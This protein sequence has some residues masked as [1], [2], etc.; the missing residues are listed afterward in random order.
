RET[1]W[2][3]IL[4]E[5]PDGKVLSLRWTA[6]L[7]GSVN[8]GLMDFARAADLDAAL[9]LADRTA[10]PTQ[11]L[12]IGDSGGNIPWRLLGPLPERGEGCPTRDLV[13]NAPASAAPDRDPEAA[14]Q[15]HLGPCPPWRID[16]AVAPVVRSPEAARLWTANSRVV[17]GE[18]LARIGDGG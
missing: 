8:L 7:P 1:R 12:V 4:H 5:L 11:N 6:Q 14:P 10:V 2:G 9:A 17:S 18:D 16:T 13:A 15:V 3:P